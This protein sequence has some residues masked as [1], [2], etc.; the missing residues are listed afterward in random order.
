[1]LYNVRQEKEGTSRFPLSHLE[2]S[3]HESESQDSAVKP[4]LPVQCRQLFPAISAPQSPLSA[5]LKSQPIELMKTFLIV[6]ASYVVA[7]AAGVAFVQTALQS[8]LQQHSGTQEMRVY[9]IKG[10]AQ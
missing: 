6:L 4:G 10:W 2:N 7:G 3:K 9:K 5:N 1:M 8:P